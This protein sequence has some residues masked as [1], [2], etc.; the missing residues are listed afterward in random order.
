M[1]LPWEPCSLDLAAGSRPP[2][3]YIIV[4]RDLPLGHL[5]AQVAHAAGSGSERHPPETHVVV[6][7]VKNEAELREVAGRLAGHGI[8]HT[9]VEESDAPYEGQAMSIGIE[10]VE[11]RTAVRKEVSSLPLLR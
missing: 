11:D 1:L 3:Q 2:T 6:L 10:L 5:A 4:R 7:A 8:G 9:L